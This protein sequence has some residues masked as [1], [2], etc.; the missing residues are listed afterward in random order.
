MNIDNV[1]SF[2]GTYSG[3]TT[4]AQG[5]IV[6]YNSSSY[7]SLINSNTGNEPDTNPSDWAL[8]AA[9]GPTGATGATGAA[10]PGAK[11]GYN[12]TGGSVS[13]SLAAG[14]Y[15]LTYQAS[16][17]SAQNVAPYVTGYSS[18]PAP[19]PTTTSENNGTLTAVGVYTLTSSGTITA[20]LY[21]GGASSALLTA[22]Q[23]S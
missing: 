6:A 4:Y 1:A 7:V 13:L 9:Q 21:A 12:S 23:V 19:M 22:V 2:Q 16:T 3:S 15:I 5:D 14:T 18:A 10:G 17:S 20:T 11:Y 8:L